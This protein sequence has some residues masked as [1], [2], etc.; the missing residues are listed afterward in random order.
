MFNTA[1]LAH[2]W[3]VK[4]TN[5]YDPDVHQLKC[6]NRWNLLV[7]I[8][9]T[10][11]CESKKVLFKTRLGS[12]YLEECARRR[13]RVVN[14]ITYQYYHN[15]I[16]TVRNRDIPHI[17][18]IDHRLTPTRALLLWF[19]SLRQLHPEVNFL[20]NRTRYIILIQKIVWKCE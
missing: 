8:T 12:K 14:Y 2:Y 17:N 15:I 10:T 19:T 18:T 3:S 5:S 16:T 1:L 6:S 9:I 4:S 20:W 11:S 7:F 13:R